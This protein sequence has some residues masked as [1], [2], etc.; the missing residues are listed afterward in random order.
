MAK[1]GREGESGETNP[2]PPLTSLFH[3]F[4]F[5][6]FFSLLSQVNYNLLTVNAFMAMTG[7]YQLGRKFGVIGG[8]GAGGREGAAV[9]KDV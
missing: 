9:A 1:R 5:L 4:L 7:L 8:E 3:S 2:K 6:S